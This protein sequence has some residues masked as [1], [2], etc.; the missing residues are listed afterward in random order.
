[1][2]ILI[3]DSK[4]AK[5]LRIN[6]TWTSD[7]R[8]AFEF[9]SVSYAVAFGLKELKGPF[10]TLE[11]ESDSLSNVTSLQVGSGR[12]SPEHTP[13]KNPLKYAMDR[14]EVRLGQ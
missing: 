4:T 14:Q 10:R 3:Q 11:I 5:F 6:S 9:L 13:R 7:V 1:M 12:L 2:I 8:E